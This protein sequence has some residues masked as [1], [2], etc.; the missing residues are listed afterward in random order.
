MVPGRR[1][2]LKMYITI[3]NFTVHSN[4]HIYEMLESHNCDQR[5][6][7]QHAHA[8]FTKFGLAFFPCSHKEPSSLRT[9]AGV[10]C[11][12]PSDNVRR[13]PGPYDKKHLWAPSHQP[14]TLDH[15]PRTC[16]NSQNLY[17]HLGLCLFNTISQS[18]TL[19]L[20]HSDTATEK[21]L[22]APL[23]AAQ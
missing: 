5:C 10:S 9:C 19:P 2:I 7:H 22:R 16:H 15:N 3:V 11:E 18:Q 8:M 12:W 21:F 6:Q 17:T 1:G 23:L 13:D 20:A 4:I 14:H